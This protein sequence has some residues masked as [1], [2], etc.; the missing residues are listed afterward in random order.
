MS[1]TLLLILSTVVYSMGLLSQHATTQPATLLEFSAGGGHFYPRFSPN[2]E[3]LLTT[4]ANYSGLKVFT[5]GDQSLKVINTDAGAGYNAQISNDG[6]SI[7]YNRVEFVNNRRQNTLMS[8][9]R[10]ENRL[11]RITEPSREKVSPRFSGNRPAFVRGR[12]YVRT[13]IP[14]AETPPLITIEDRK[15]VIY[16]AAGR[17]VL[18]PNGGDA[19]Y[20]W[21]SFSPDGRHIVYTVAGRGTFVS[22]T[23]GSAVRSLGALNA[24]QWLN[25]QWVVGM[26]DRDDGAR[27]VASDLY[28]VSIDG[29]KRQRLNTPPGKIAMYPAVSPEGNRIAFNTDQGEIYIMSI[30]IQ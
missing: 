24:P 27:V 11:Q 20:I 14:A 13:G 3:F 25:N 17:R 8:F 21:P 12:T 10:K 23:D 30:T 19:S 18:D 2:S 9:S 4:R 1:K 28:V 7:L 26:D 16:T 15:M 29:K 6:T 5:F 22:R